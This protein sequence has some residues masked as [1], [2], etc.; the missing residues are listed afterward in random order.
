MLR[1]LNYLLSAHQNS[2]Y[3][4]CWVLFYTL[5]STFSLVALS[6]ATLIHAFVSGCLFKSVRW[7]R[8]GWLPPLATHP[9]LSTLWNRRHWPSG[10]PASALPWLRHF[11]WGLAA[12]TF[13]KP[14]ANRPFLYC[15]GYACGPLIWTLLPL[16]QP[17]EIQTC[18]FKSKAVSLRWPSCLLLSVLS[19]R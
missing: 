9:G 3:G 13:Q 19:K 2:F 6:S 10:D 14:P 11:S 7:I 12:M 4:Y 17:Y 8:S 18:Y 15:Q 16:L 5:N 1:S